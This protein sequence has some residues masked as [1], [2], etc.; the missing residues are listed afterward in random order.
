MVDNLTPLNI[1]TGVT[2]GYAN[3]IM[4]ITGGTGAWGGEVRNYNSL[5]QVTAI[6]SN[7]VD[8]SYAYSPTQ[9]NGKIRSQTD[10][11]SGETVTYTYDSLNRL[12]EAQ[13][14]SSW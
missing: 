4:A 9:N 2:Y 5:K 1:I 10:G 3:E 11:V 7:G 8:V 13:S 12:L 6:G 14:S